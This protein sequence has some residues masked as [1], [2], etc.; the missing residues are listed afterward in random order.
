[1]SQSEVKPIIIIQSDE[2]P[3]PKGYSYRI[4]L[5]KLLSTDLKRK[6]GILNAYYLP[7]AG[8]NYLYPDISPVNSFRII[9]NE[10]FGK[11]YKMLKEKHFLTNYQYSHQFI[12]VTNRLKNN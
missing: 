12:D 10:Y 4:E 2:G 1:M 9:F 11:D 3:Y 7:D 6:F 5:H 8:N